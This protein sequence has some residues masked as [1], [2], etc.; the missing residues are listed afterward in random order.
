MEIKKLE[1]LKGYRNGSSVAHGLGIYY[2]IDV[3]HDGAV[4]A[5]YEGESQTKSIHSTQLGAKNWAQSQ[6][7]GRIM[8]WVNG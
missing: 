7:D 8:E 3:D 5:A 6:H 1:W 4:L 2:V